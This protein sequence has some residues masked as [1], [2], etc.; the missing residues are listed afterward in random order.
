[1]HLIIRVNYV[2]ILFALLAVIHQLIVLFPVMMVVILVTQAANVVLVQQVN[3]L[4]M[5]N[6][7]IVI[8]LNVLH[9]QI[10]QLI[11]CYRVI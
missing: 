8:L 7:N 10:M 6:A 4:L 3:I 1:M 9:A 11:A 2:I 5:D